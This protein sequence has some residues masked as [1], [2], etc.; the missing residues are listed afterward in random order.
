L[1]YDQECLKFTLN[2]R[3]NSVMCAL[4]RISLWERAD[5]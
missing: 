4:C 2:A 1:G 3:K 5:M